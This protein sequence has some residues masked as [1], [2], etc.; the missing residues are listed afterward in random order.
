MSNPPIR[1]VLATACL[2]AGASLPTAGEARAPVIALS[3]AYYGNI[4]RHQMVESFSAAAKEAKRRGEISDFVVLNGDGSVNQQIAQFSDLVLRHVDVIAVDAA[5]DTAL[6]GVV[7]KACAAGIKVLA[8]DSVLSA[9]CAYKLNFDFTGYQS[10]M[11]QWIVDKIG[12]KG[13]VI[14]ARGVKG[15]SPDSDMYRAQMGVLAHYPDVKV[16]VTVYGQATDAVAQTAVANVLPSLPH[17]DAVLDQGGAYGIAEAFEQFGGAYAAKPPIIGEGG[18][19]ADFFRWW[20]EQK[21]KNGYS[22]IAMYS[23]PGVGGAAF[24]LALDLAKGKKASRTMIMPAVTVTDADLPHF[25]NQ[26]PGT[27][28]SPSYD[29]AWVERHL[30]SGR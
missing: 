30:L 4:F 23:T 21:Q 6:N 15:S 5:S 12:H 14:V 1:A 10:R 9:P 7:A 24:W 16:A 8:F 13:N 20:A 17:I 18:G 11:T 2:L 26:K 25:A 19:T 27:I 22:T 28:V 3:N 29:A